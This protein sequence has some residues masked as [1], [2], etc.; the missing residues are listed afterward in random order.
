MLSLIVLELT[1]FELDKVL[2]SGYTAVSPEQDWFDLTP[3]HNSN[4][5]AARRNIN[6]CN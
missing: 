1:E 6:R 2:E 5:L 3:V 4:R